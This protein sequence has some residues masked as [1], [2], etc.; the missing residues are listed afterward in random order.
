MGELEPP[1]HPVEP[2]DERSDDADRAVG[3]SG[4]RGVA[5]AALPDL[6][7][8]LRMRLPAA[9]QRPE[10]CH[11]AA[12]PSGAAATARLRHD[13]RSGDEAPHRADLHVPA[14]PAALRR[15]PL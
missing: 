12:A 15:A 4:A 6:E 5:L 2:G 7:C 10:L 13:R 11:V 14:L 3:A 1:P 9:R 8:A